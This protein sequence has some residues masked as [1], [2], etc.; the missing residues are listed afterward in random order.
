MLRADESSERVPVDERL[1][2][3]DDERRIYQRGFERGCAAGD[4]CR[5]RR[6]QSLA[7]FVLRDV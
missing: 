2:I 3:D 6:R 4:G 1:F 5:I 7:R